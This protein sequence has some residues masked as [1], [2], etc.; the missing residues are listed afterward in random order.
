[1]RYE[2]DINM[3]ETGQQVNFVCSNWPYWKDDSDQGFTGSGLIVPE[4]SIKYNR[5]FFDNE[6]AYVKIKRDKNLT[7][8]FFKICDIRFSSI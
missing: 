2:L 5:I 1:M 8:R 3:Q 4:N 7:D 6:Q